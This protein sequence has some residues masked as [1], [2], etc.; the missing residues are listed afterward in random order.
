MTSPML[1]GLRSLGIAPMNAASQGSMWASA[2]RARHV[3]AVSLA[4]DGPLARR[5]SPGTRVTAH[6][7]HSLPHYRL[8]PSFL[9]QYASLLALRDFTHLLN[10]GN[11]PLVKSPHRFSF[12]DELEDG[13]FEDKCV[14]VVFHG[15]DARDPDLA[16]DLDSAHFFHDAD[17]DWIRQVRA[18]ATRNRRQVEE[19]GVPTYVTTP[20]MLRH[21]HGAQLL[22]LCV[23][24]AAWITPRPAME[25]GIPTVLHRSSGARATKGTK[26]IRPVLE[27]LNRAGRI[28]LLDPPVVAHA[29]MA[30]LIKK[31][32]IVVDQLQ[33]G[34]Y[35]VTGI[36]AMAAGRLVIAN[37]SAHDETI[38][39]ARPP[40]LH[41]T[42]ASF[43]QAMEE[44]LQSADAMRSLASTG[45]VYASRFHDGSES[46]RV[47]TAFLE[48]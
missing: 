31:S 10:E 37:I 29:Q 6:A 15:T 48:S 22:P 27:A 19:L 47:L 17:S 42:P 40:I 1:G 23:D 43:Q 13:L 4:H 9:R 11:V 36:E 2:L 14:A 45:P 38:C 41:A 7:D 26:Y 18:R 34:T 3:P 16:K 25:G 35:G 8:A 39:T 20:D 28:R 33:S 32:D 12:A 24:I 44:A 5:L 21:V 46:V 30:E